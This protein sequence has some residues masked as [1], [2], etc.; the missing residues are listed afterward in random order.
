MSSS[1]HSHRK[2]RKKS[3]VAEFFD[4]F[5]KKE[6]HHSHHRSEFP[7]INLPKDYNPETWHKDNKGKSTSGSTPENV[8]KDFSDST[9]GNLDQYQQEDV[10]SGSLKKKKSIVAAIEFYFK[11]RNIRREERQEMRIRKKLHREQRHEYQKKE[12]AQGISRN[13]FTIT[14][15][16]EEE[17]IRKRKAR[18]FSQ[19]NPL[20]RNLTIAVNS[21]FV[22]L[23]TYVLVY[24]FYWLTS[25]L[26]ASWYGLDST[27]YF[28]DLKFN[29]HSNVWNR[30]NILM[31][32]GIPPFFCLFLGLFLYR[33]V[34]KMK[35]IVGLQ[36]LVI[37]WSSFHLF[38][39]FF[40]AFPAG[41]V[42]DEGFGYVAAWLYMNTA[43][44]FMFSIISLFVL[45]VIGYYSAQHIL[46]TSDSLHRIKQENRL[47]FILMQIALPWLIGTA[48]MLLIRAPKNFDYPYET[49]MLF[50][51]VFLV[52]PPFFND[53]VKPKLN[54]LR[55]KK[56]RYINMGYFAMML[57]LLLFLR[58][59]LGIG[60]HFVIEIHISI[61]PAVT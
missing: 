5:K 11:Q 39:H 27:L 61:S 46:E 49:L 1:G 13:L 3:A 52:I 6:P 55:V 15:D 60:L 50:S 42:T 9:S 33:V 12:A 47:A 21:L 44:K 14:E 8:D 34:F 41:V 59:M 29:D 26:V 51:T 45:A 24:L 43:F 23:L 58:I 30:F 19:R 35:R 56:K 57:A 32:T 20:F 25:M 36:K 38:N 31:V 53:K 54:L 16:E 18:L 37:L 40:G 17:I 7:G 48:I 22:F 28:Y 2:H 10:R 4:L